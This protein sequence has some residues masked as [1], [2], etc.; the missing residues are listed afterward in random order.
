MHKKI[1][2]PFRVK[3]LNNPKANKFT[4]DNIGETTTLNKQKE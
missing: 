2:I 1:D 3:W 4:G